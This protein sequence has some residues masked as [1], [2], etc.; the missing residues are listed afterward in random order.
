MG[1]TASNMSPFPLAYKI[2]H[3]VASSVT[4]TFLLFIRRFK[5][6]SKYSQ[7]LVRVDSE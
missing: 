7:D 2:G 5:V 6:E 3:T 4:V 1:S